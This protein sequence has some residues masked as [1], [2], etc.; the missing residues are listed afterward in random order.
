MGKEEVL[1]DGANVPA[2]DLNGPQTAGS[3]NFMEKYGE[4]RS[5]RI[6]AEGYKQYIDL[7]Q[8]D[9][10]NSFAEDPWIDSGTPVNAPVEDGGHCKVAIIGA[11][12][13]GIL[14]AVRLIKAGFSPD[15]L[16]IIDPAGGF[17]GT[18]YWNRYPGLMCD[19]E[20]YI[21]LPLIEEMGYMPKRRY[22]SGYEIREYAESVCTRFDLHQRAMFQSRGQSMTWDDERKEWIVKISKKPKGGQESLHTVRASFTIIASGVLNNP[23]LPDLEGINDFKGHMFHSARWD[24]NYTGGTPERPDLTGLRGKKVAFIGTGAT[25]VQAV[26]ELAKF[27]EKLYI[28]Q[29]T[30][31]AVDARDNCDTDPD[32][33]KNN[34]ATKPGWYRERNLNF[35]TYLE[36]SEPKPAKNLVN[37]AWTK[38]PS[39]SGLIGTNK[40]VSMENIQEHL[41]ELHALDYARQERVRQRASDIVD[42]QETAARLQAWYPGWCK[43]PCFHDEYLQTFNSPNVVLVDTDGK[44]VDR[45]TEKGVEFAGEQYEVDLLIWGT[46]F[47]SPFIG[48]PAG[49]ADLTVNGKN[50]LSM[51]DVSNSGDLL[52]LFGVT[53][54]GFPNLYFPGPMQAGISANFTFTTDT[55]AIHVAYIMSRAVLGGEVNNTVVVEPSQEAQDD[56]AMQIMSGAVTFAG[57]QGCTPSY[58]NKEGEADLIEDKM[59]AAKNSIWPNGFSSYVQ[60]LE[61]YRAKDNLEGLEVSYGA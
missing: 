48:S 7:G 9:R 60:L 2:P 43:R 15:D 5:K 53:A 20:S 8:S 55:M 18:W 52:T 31:S 50:G 1:P 4:E 45:I 23:K 54:R 47:R 39:Y 22:A 12:F 30:P 40:P 3:L 59:K 27:A 36:N 6:R 56:W 29:R 21:Y 19:V 44:G 13:G 28:F 26:P 16:L 14:F 57:M 51:E 41:G 37:D 38:F 33:W 46:G 17:G 61:D 34:V 10:L 42:D 11:G 35:S 25:A 49:R 32:F 58:L 24:Y